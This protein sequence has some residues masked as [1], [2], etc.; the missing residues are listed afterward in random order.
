[1]NNDITVTVT[2]ADRRAGSSGSGGA[3]SAGGSGGDSPA[4]QEV[5]QAPGADDAGTTADAPGPMSLDDLGSGGTAAS[6][7]S[8]SEAPAP[9]PA[10]GGTS[11][12]DGGATAPGPDDVGAPDG[13]DEPEEE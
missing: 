9:D 13:E 6:A 11:S 7:G 8:S 5:G 2:V 12:S 1:M 4:P 3:G 10:L